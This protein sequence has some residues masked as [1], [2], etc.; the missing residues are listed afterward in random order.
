MTEFSYSNRTLK[1]VTIKK[2]KFGNVLNFNLVKVQS[3]ATFS[4]YN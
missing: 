2:G 4:L 1:Q 3:G